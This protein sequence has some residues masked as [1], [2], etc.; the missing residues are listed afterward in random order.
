[1]LHPP[2]T[3]T[4]QRTRAPWLKRVGLPLAFAFAAI[5]ALSLGTDAGAQ[6]AGAGRI[7]GTVTDAANGGPLSSVAVSVTGT[8]LGAVTD[9]AGKYS[10]NGVPAG[11]H[12][13]ET[14]RIG[15]TPK[16]VPGVVVTAGATTTVDVQLTAGA[17]TLEAVVTTGVVD[18]TS[19]T[20]VPFTVG[21]VDAADA[22]VPATNAVE[23]IQ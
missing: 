18:P 17:L 12:A 22:P 4:R 7:S 14:R 9:M 11:T 2:T 21:R 15:Y 8:R 10:I 23:T 6:E 3:G 5:M 19:G 1:M 13:L 20:R 16:H